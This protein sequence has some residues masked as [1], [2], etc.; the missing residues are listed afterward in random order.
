MCLGYP[1]LQVFAASSHLPSPASV[2]TN[3]NHQ[4]LTHGG[5]KLDALKWNSFWFGSQSSPT[6]GYYT[7][8]FLL[9]SNGII[10]HFKGTP[11]KQDGFSLLCT[12]LLRHCRLN[13]PGARSPLAS[14]YS[15]ES[16]F[17]PGWSSTFLCIPVQCPNPAGV[18]RCCGSRDNFG[19]VISG[20]NS[21]CCLS[22]TSVEG[23][24]SGF[25]LAGGRGFSTVQGW[26]HGSPPNG[27]TGWWWL[28][29][30]SE[31]ILV[32]S[33]LHLCCSLAALRGKINGSNVVVWGR[34][35]SS[36]PPPLF[37]F[38]SLSYSHFQGSQI[39]FY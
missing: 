7:I 23:V 4:P 17:L 32:D 1:V 3:N 13:L 35:C 26:P 24:T 8:Y 27:M 21:S 31:K 18:P 19:I 11:L 12:C 34:T 30:P 5:A 33:K 28:V 9:L 25:L 2:W 14:L 15:T 29:N 16:W 37:Y 10:K 39:V 20:R 6:C 36:L 38:L 22:K